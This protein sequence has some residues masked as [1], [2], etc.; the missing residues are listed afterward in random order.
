M[1]AGRSCGRKP[2]GEDPAGVAARLFAENGM[3]AQAAEEARQAVA[4][5]PDDISYELG[6]VQQQI[7][8][9]PDA[10]ETFVR[11]LA[12]APS[13]MSAEIADARRRLAALQ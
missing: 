8:K 12:I 7:G 10:R 4:A 9:G 6:M 13:A 5:N 3:W 1:T 2:A 11:F